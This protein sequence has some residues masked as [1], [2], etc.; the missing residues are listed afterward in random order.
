VIYSHNN[1]YIKRGQASY[2]AGT[3]VDV[4]SVIGLWKTVRL[5]TITEGA[6]GGPG[7]MAWM[8]VDNWWVDNYQDSYVLTTNMTG[9]L[10][11]SSFLAHAKDLNSGI[12]ITRDA[13]I[14]VQNMQYSIDDGSSYTPVV[15]RGSDY[16]FGSV[17]SQAR[18]KFIMNFDNTSPLQMKMSVIEGWGMYYY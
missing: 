8:A 9:L 2:D 3:S 12:G 18:V 16:T 4:S 14:R 5:Y 10:P 7:A 6:S 1:W 11:S 15:Q 17:S 13:G